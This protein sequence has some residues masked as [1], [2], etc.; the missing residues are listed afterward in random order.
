MFTKDTLAKKVVIVT[1]GGSG[2]GLSMAKHAASLGARLVLAARD[3][4]RLKAAVE[5]VKE[6]G[7]D[8]GGTA[9]AVPTDVRDVAQVKAMVARAV[10][11]YGQVDGLIN[12]AA[13]NFL[14]ASED[15]SPNGFD[16]VVKIVLYG[17][18]N[19]TLEVGRHLLE[20]KAPGSIVSIVTS[21]AWTGSAFVLPSAC[22]KSGVLA[23]T[24]S[25]A[26]EWA[27][28][29]IRLNA[30]APGPFPTEGAWK[31]LVP[32]GVEDQARQ[33]VPLGRFGEHVELANVVAFL[34]SDMATFQTGDCVTIDGGEWL[35]NGGEFNGYARGPR[36]PV[37]QLFRAMRGK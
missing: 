36:E 3:E 17:T 6:A 24:R 8:A 35:G 7:R 26:I 14:C 2:L 30:V 34:L 18:V 23:M 31:A 37:K 19:C 12:N 15:L 22:A 32:Q 11:E 27:H 1:G 21:Y 20:R 25:L 16:A 9:I 28:A 10:T 4:T 29:G 33:R 13:G 5:A